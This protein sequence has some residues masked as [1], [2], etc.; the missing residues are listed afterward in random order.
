MIKNPEYCLSGSL[1]FVLFS[2]MEFYLLLIF[3]GEDVTSKGTH[4]GHL[5]VSE[6]RQYQQERDREDL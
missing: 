4:V 2:N 5:P 6:K 3:K 1:F